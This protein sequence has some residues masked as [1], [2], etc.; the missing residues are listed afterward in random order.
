[1]EYVIRGLGFLITPIV[2]SG[3]IAFLRQP[4]EAQKER[5]YLPKIIVALGSIIVGRD[6]KKYGKRIVRLF[7]KGGY[8][9]Y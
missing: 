3:T 1:M 8:V 6:P 4:K 9:R 5:V 7:F 2:V